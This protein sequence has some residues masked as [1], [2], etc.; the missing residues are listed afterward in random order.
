M[1]SKN[2]IL[3]FIGKVT[4]GTLSLELVI[5]NIVSVVCVAALV[6]AG[7]LAFG[8]A[9][10]A[11]ALDISDITE[12]FGH[13]KTS[14]TSHLIKEKLRNLQKLFKYFNETTTYVSNIL[15]PAAVSPFI[16]SLYSK[17]LFVAVLLLF[18]R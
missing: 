18:I 5:W 3:S 9:D 1:F 11:V 17:Y 6:W 2:L 13:D 10:T 15:L 4:T 14:S 16:F 12:F 8:L 7:G